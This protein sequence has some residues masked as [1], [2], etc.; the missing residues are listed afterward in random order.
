MTDI[1][2]T[3]SPLATWLL[4]TP[5][6]GETHC[7]IDVIILNNSISYLLTICGTQLKLPQWKKRTLAVGTMTNVGLKNVCNE[8]KS[9]PPPTPNHL[10]INSYPNEK[11]MDELYHI[12][13]K[14][15]WKIKYINCLACARSSSHF[16]FEKNQQ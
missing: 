4:F 9:N 7:G 3:F 10:I 16:T 6:H 14:W 1:L 15:N 8:T 11:R 2:T 13:L 12:E 5:F